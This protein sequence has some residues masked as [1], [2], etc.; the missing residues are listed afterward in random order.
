MAEFCKAE[1][2]VAPIAS[3]RSWGPPNL[4]TVDPFR[5]V[6]NEVAK[7]EF[8]EAM[9]LAVNRILPHFPHEDMLLKHD[10]HSRSFGNIYNSKNLW[11]FPTFISTHPKNLSNGVAIEA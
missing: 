5:K 2:D 3:Q 9:P 7:E 6:D 11:I 4:C 8:R 1:H 10:I